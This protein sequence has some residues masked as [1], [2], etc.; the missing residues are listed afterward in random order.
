MPGARVAGL[1]MN[2]GRVSGVSFFY[3][4]S[5]GAA[6]FLDAA[7]QITIIKA[8]WLEVERNFSM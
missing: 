6:V 5:L 2:R 1:E 8:P 3:T 7:I 4:K